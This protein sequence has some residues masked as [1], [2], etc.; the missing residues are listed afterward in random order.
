MGKRLIV[1][2][3]C[4]AGMSAAAKAKRTQ[5]DLE[6]VVF[7]KGS[8]I[9][10][11]ACGMPY[12]IAGDISDHRDLIVRTPEQMRKQGVDVRINHRVTEIDAEERTVTVRDRDEGRELSIGYDNLVIAT[13]ARA[14]FPPIEHAQLEGVFGLRSLE[15]GLAVY[16]FLSERK[17]KSAVI[18]GGGYIGVE[19]AETFRRLGMHTSMLIRS[20]Q[21]LRATLDDDV[22]L[23]IDPFRPTAVLAFHSAPAV[24]SPNWRIIAA[25]CQEL[26]GF[27]QSP[28]LSINTKSRRRICPEH[29]ASS[30]SCRP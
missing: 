26:H 8:F 7:E 25:G 1:V 18:I 20:G 23:H 15:S 9:S 28:I 27:G 14:A 6:V 11:A 12:Y 22:H 17:P 4:A 5:R 29:C 21:V 2:G 19:M 10:Y 30:S 16:R 3:G 24:G 13:G